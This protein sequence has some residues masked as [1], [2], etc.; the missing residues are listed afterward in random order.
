MTN[1]TKF[2]D[3]RQ[4][5]SSGFAALMEM[6]KETNANVSQ[7]RTELADGALAQKLALEDVLADAF[8]EGDPIGHRK[9]HEAVIKAAEQ[10]AKFWT[11]MAASVAKWGLVGLVGW[12]VN[13][14]WQ[15]LLQGPHK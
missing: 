15:G 8:P 9:H 14:A 11:D 3:R 10:R 2:E 1:A 5:Q 6:V 13:L 7:L 4:S 12:M